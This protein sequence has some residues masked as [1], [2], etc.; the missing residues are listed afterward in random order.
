MKKIITLLA[1]VT[2]LQQSTVAQNENALNFDGFDDQVTAAN[3]SAQIVN[4]TAGIS[5]S[6]WVYASNPSPASQILMAL[7]ALEMNLTSTFTCFTLTLQL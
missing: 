4:S 6:C 3:A 5:I 7:L 2:F 1:V